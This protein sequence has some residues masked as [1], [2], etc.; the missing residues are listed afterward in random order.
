MI[1]AFKSKAK[2]C[3]STEYARLAR[4]LGSCEMESNTSE[5][6][7]ACYRRAAKTSGRRAKQC[8]TEG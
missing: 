3:C 4:R 1:N 8:I 2:R 7:H 5:E 6:K